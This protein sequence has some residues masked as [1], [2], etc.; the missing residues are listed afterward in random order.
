MFVTWAVLFSGQDVIASDEDSEAKSAQAVNAS[1]SL[2]SLLPLITD[3]SIAGAVLYPRQFLESAAVRNLPIELV[4]ADVERRLGVDPRKI[5]FVIGF[6][7]RAPTQP[8]SIGL[9]TRATGR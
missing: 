1:R 7:E 4:A 8:L 2:P 3:E 5:E 9:M 6:L